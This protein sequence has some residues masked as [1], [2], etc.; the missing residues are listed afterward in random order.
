MTIRGCRGIF[1]GL[2]AF[3]MLIFS[4]AV[5]TVQGVLGHGTGRANDVS[6]AVVKAHARALE[7][8]TYVPR[9]RGHTI[10]YPTKEKYG[11]SIVIMYPK[12]SGSGIKASIL[13]DAV[14]RLAGIK[15]VGVKVQVGI[16]DCHALQVSSDVL[17]PFGASMK[18]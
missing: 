7:R 1:D 11:K 6:S 13:V 17:G 3:K 12:T 18:D 4:S 14:C 5:F 9:Y 8:L 2:Y 16:L 15:D 10:Y